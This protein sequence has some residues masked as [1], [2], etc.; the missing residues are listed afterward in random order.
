MAKPSR[1]DFEPAFDLSPPGS[2]S[3]PNGLDIAPP[4]L[5][6]DGHLGGPNFASTDGLSRGAAHLASNRRGAQRASSLRQAPRVS[7][8]ARTANMRRLPKVGV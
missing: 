3:A 4:D 6:A 1:L 7:P 5:L 8:G 2:K